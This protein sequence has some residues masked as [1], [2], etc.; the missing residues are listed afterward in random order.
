[1]DVPH[2][3]S[4]LRDIVHRLRE[5]SR[6]DIFLA[7]FTTGVLL[8]DREHDSVRQIAVMGERKCSAASTTFSQIDS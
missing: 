8:V 4:D 1:M 7:Q 5:G 3:H 2:H 6:L